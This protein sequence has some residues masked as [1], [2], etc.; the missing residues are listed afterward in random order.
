MSTFDDSRKGGAPVRSIPPR[1][2]V[3]LLAAARRK[4]KLLRWLAEIDWAG[5]GYRD[6]DEWL[7]EHFGG[8]KPNDA[9][10]RC[11]EVFEKEG[12]L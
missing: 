2:Q 8:V 9:L 1:T 7:L 3:E 4:E 10:L 6:K 11:Q 5:H 12:L